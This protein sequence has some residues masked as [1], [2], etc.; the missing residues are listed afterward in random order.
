[1]TMTEKILA[2]H[3]D[4]PSVMPGDNV[5]T[6]VDKLMTHDVCGPG[7]FGI[8]Q[9][10]FG[11]DAQVGCMQAD[12]CRASCSRG[13]PCTCPSP[14]PAV[15]HSMHV[16][17]LVAML[18]PHPWQV[19]DPERVV[20]IPDHYI[21]TSDPRANRNVDILREVAQRYGIK[22]FYDIQNR[23][24]FQANPDYK[25]VCH[26]A[27]AQEGHCKP[28]EQDEGQRGAIAAWVLGPHAACAVWQRRDPD[29][30]ALQARCCLAPTPTPATPAPLASL[31]PGWATPMLASSWAPA[32]C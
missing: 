1:M 24:D 26:V 19:W 11:E 16:A 10:E 9:K 12:S 15:A 14:L 13:R 7:T 2:Q 17:R 4:K 27:L 30:P 5:W 8:F 29:H 18:P 20:I 23:G 6:K 22:Y 32:S 28:G 21:F 25:G 31:P 3:S